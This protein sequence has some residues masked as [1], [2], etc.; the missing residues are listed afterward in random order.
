MRPVPS[1]PNQPGWIV[2]IVPNRYS[3]LTMG[4]SSFPEGLRQISRLESFV[5]GRGLHEIVVATPEHND[6]ADGYTTSQWDALLGACQDRMAQLSSDR[7]IRHALLFENHGADG[8]G[9]RRHPQLQ[10]MGLPLVPKALQEE[11]HNAREYGRKTSSCLFCDVLS[12]EVREKSRVVAVDEGFVTYAP[13]AS[14]IP[15]ELCVMPRAHRCSFLEV[16]SGDRHRLAEHLHRVL[17]GLGAMFEGLAYNW[18]LHTMVPS[19]D[20][21][22]VFHWHIEIMPQLNRQDGFEWGAGAFMNAT[23]PEAAANALRRTISQRT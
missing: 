17:A 18:V 6:R 19:G 23:S 10:L 8:N 15:Y 9:H 16:P 21:G 20:I 11:V 12:R 14:R 13:W 22:R 3:A 1:E 2:R 4:D 7:R 5:P